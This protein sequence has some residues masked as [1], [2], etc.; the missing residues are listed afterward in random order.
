[1]H[2]SSVLLIIEIIDR[3]RE[4]SPTSSLHFH[5]YY[6]KTTLSTEMAPRREER[7]WSTPGRKENYKRQAEG[8]E[9]EHKETN[10][11]WAFF[12]ICASKIKKRQNEKEQPSGLNSEQCTAE[13]LKSMRTV[14]PCMLTIT[15]M[16]CLENHTGHLTMSRHSADSAEI[17][18]PDAAILTGFVCICN[19]AMEREASAGFN[20]ASERKRTHTPNSMAVMGGWA[21]NH[22]PLQKAGREIKTL[23]IL[24]SLYRI[25]HITHD[26]LYAKAINCKTTRTF[27]N[28]ILC[29]VIVGFLLFPKQASFW[30]G[31]INR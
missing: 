15:Q 14:L 11:G 6:N 26:L 13:A 7:L 21:K 18:S 24:T 1:M 16:V 4:K 22:H 8:A 27:A 10:T 12:F 25:T 9:E 19:S 5:L 28:D 31:K 3:C 30:V 2:A 20:R 29:Y 23:W 17:Q